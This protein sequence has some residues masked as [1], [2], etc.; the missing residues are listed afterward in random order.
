M[1]LIIRN[2]TDTA[3]QVTLHASLPAGWTEK[4]E[5]TVYTVAAHDSYPIQLT[6]HSSAAQKDTWQTLT[7]K[8]ESSGQNFGSVTLRVDVVSNGLPQ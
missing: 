2:D 4:P 3:K 5:A 1:P 6:V 7:W 8:A